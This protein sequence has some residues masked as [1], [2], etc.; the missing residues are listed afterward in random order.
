[1]NGYGLPVDRLALQRAARRWIWALTGALAGLLGVL[2]WEADVWAQREQLQQLLQGLRSAARAPAAAS[3][4]PPP[5]MDL[6]DRL[7]TH[8]SASRLGLDLQS[9]LASLGLQV[10][11]LRPQALQTGGPLPSQA[12]V[13]HLQGRWA[14]F[15]HA[16]TTL[17]DAGPVWTIDR[18][19]VVPDAS[20]GTLQWEGVW[21]AWLRPDAAAEQAWPVGWVTAPRPGGSAGRDP[22]VSAVSAR[23]GPALE[24]SEAAAAALPTDP[25][26]WPL[27]SVR[28]VG[29]WQQADQALAVLSAGPHWVALGTGASLALE[30]YRVKAIHPESVELQPLKGGGLTQV[31]RLERGLP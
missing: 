9:G 21:R 19:T 27:T 2:G 30:G 14:D 24:A 1:M 17:V 18:L 13:V 11:A 3:S 6:I 4:A 23:T 22:L 29:V 16:W 8:S 10:L 20:A 7:P 15:G 5:S 12:M 25:R 31:L 28:L 26:Q